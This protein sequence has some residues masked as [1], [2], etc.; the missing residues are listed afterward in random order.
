MFLSLALK[1]PTS[2]LYNIT[3]ASSHTRPVE[4]GAANPLSVMNL[5]TVH[6]LFFDEFNFSF[7]S[8]RIFVF[9]ELRHCQVA[10]VSIS[11]V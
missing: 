5:E 4:P 1:P 3:F 6:L 11:T 7:V 8:W 9:C 2:I 10:S